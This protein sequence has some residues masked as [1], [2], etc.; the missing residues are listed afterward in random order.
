MPHDRLGPCK[1]QINCL[2]PCQRVGVGCEVNLPGAPDGHTGDGR[3]PK[4]KPVIEGVLPGDP[5][6]QVLIAAQQHPDGAFPLRAGKAAPADQ[7]MENITETG[8]AIH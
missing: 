2:G 3:F 5:G 1:V 6:D 7:R 4:R 8:V